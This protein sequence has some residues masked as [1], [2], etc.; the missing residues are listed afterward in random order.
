MHCIFFGKNRFVKIYGG[1]RYLAL[2]GPE[3]YVIY[4]SIK[5]LI[6]K[7][8]GITDIISHNFARIVIDSYNSF[9]YRKNSNF[10]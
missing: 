3:K 6:S 7:K 1:T 5:Y 9:T 4:N 10:S 2:F 8:S